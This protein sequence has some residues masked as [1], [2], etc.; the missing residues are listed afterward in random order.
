MVEIG[1]RTDDYW[2]FA[3]QAS[4]KAASYVPDVHDM[5]ELVFVGRLVGCWR[6][7]T[8]FRLYELFYKGLFAEP[9]I[10]LPCTTTAAFRT[11]P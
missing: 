6:S 5:F 11:Q 8:L 7:K 4:R 1:G 10:N 3:F 9:V 2:N